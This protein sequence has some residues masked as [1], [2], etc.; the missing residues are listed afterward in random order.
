MNYH[1]DMFGQF[2]EAF[3]GNMEGDGDIPVRDKL[4]TSKL[5]YS[6]ESLQEVDRYLEIVYKIK[7]SDSSKEYQNL[8]VWAGAYIGE[9]I[10]RNADEEYHWVQYNE[11][12][13]NKDASLKN[14]VPLLLTTHAFLVVV[15]SDYMTMP[16]N[17][18]ARRLDEGSSN[19]VHFYAA[20]DISRKSGSRNQGDISN[21]KTKPWWKIW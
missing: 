17:K 1:D 11:Y 3:L 19:N 5:D 15:E 7:I 6:L 9:V 20:G 10:R 13:E 12:M 14:L 21:S 8:V 4:T 2:A 16:I 18:V